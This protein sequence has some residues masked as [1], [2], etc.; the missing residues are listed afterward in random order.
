MRLVLPA[1]VLQQLRTDLVQGDE[2]ERFAYLY[3]GQ[4]SD[5]L[6]VADVEVVPTDDLEVFSKGACRPALDVERSYVASCFD[7]G[8]IPVMIHSHPFSDIPGFSGVDVATMG[9]YHTWLSGLHP[10]SPFGFGVIGRQGLATAVYDPDRDSFTDLP[11]EVVGSWELDRDWAIPTDHPDMDRELVN[12]QQFDRN[13]RAL[14]E[15]GQEQLA[16][17]HV[18]VVGCGGIG[19]IVLEELARLGIQDFTLIDPDIVEESNLPRLVGTMQEHVGRPK[20]DVL[21]QHLWHVAPNCS[22]TT[23]Q[24]PVQEA[25]DELLDVD[26]TVAG[27][28]TVSARMWLNEYA[29]RQ[30]QPYIDA[31]V[32][33]ETADETATE[34]HGFIQT[35]VPGVTGC[36]TCLNRGD[37]EQ[38][39]R[40]QLS[41]EEVEEQV[42][43]GYIDE[44]E[45]APEPA[46][47]QLNGAVASMAVNELVKLVTGFD[48]PTGFMRYEGIGHSLVPMET[49]PSPACPTCGE[50][51]G[52]GNESTDHIE[53]DPATDIDIPA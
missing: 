11:V 47:I 20:V 35:V 32:I 31:G 7:E 28:D 29:V 39:R 41:D 9:D 14:G 30:L 42:E 46:V 5:R 23:V 15:D 22:V 4:T 40:E 18:A 1:P 10:D 13:I 34:M 8:L 36:F 12:H 16:T 38:A 45:L 50:L 43:R 26:V 48:D 27:V 51:L 2:R 17:T 53:D 24:A 6:T 19:S 33:I 49:L 37:H 25:E 21:E 52:R 3:C 44:G